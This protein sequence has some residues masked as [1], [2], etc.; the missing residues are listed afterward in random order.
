[1]TA[2]NR[3]CRLYFWM[4]FAVE[5]VCGR[6]P[7]WF[8]TVFLPYTLLAFPADTLTELERVYATMTRLSSY[9]V[10]PNSGRTSCSARATTWL[11]FFC[12]TGSGRLKAKSH[13]VSET[14][15]RSSRGLRKCVDHPN[16]QQPRTTI[17]FWSSF[18][19]VQWLCCSPF[20]P[21]AR[22]WP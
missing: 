2:W 17:F 10:A 7:R 5:Y 15:H 12:S 6:V 8:V 21:I 18:S 1:M 16:L 11:R 9:P 22:S 4:A 14:S 13:S 3:C 19:G 20:A